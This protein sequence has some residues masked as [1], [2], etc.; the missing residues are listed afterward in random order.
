MDNLPRLIA[1]YAEAAGL[2]ESTVSRMFGGRWDV[3]DRAREGRITGRRVARI[4][5]RISDHWPADAEW[6]SDITRPSSREAA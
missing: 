5:Q 1:A 4:I 3:A 2:A 6:P